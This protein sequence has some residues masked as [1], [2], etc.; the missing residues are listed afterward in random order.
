MNEILYGKKVI[1][2][3]FE[4]GDLKHFVE[5]HRQ[6][7]NGYLGQYCLKDMTEEEAGKYVT[8]LLLTRQIIAWSVN[9]KEG[10]ATRQIGFVYLHDITSFSCGI[11]GV[12]DYK[13]VKGLGKL[14]REKKYTF[15][16]DTSRVIISY[17]FNGFNK[18]RVETSVLEDN[19]RA[20][21]LDRKVG[22][23]QEGIAR[24]AIKVNDEFKN[25]RLMSILKKEWENE[26][27]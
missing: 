12:M 4:A 23:V 9:T 27:K 11:S 8:A 13:I 21:A 20:L 18:E 1:L 19:R 7:N 22:W 5:L 15:A 24:N 17:C 14:I 6:D 3:P 10:K 26:Q 2:F 25:I 16:E